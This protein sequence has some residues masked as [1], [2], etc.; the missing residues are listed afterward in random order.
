MEKRDLLAVV[1]AIGL[2]LIVALIIK[3]ALQGEGAAFFPGSGT[4][5]EFIPTPKA[6]PIAGPPT[7]E[8]TPTPLWDGT[9]RDV[10]FVNPATYHVEMAEPQP[11]AGI[12]AQ[13]PRDNLDLTTYATIDG[14]WSGTTEIITIPF[15]YWELYYTVTGMTDPG[16]VFPTINIQ[17]MDVSDPNRFVRIINPGVLDSRTWSENDPR[18][19]IEKFYEGERSYYFIITTRF[20][21]SYSMEIKVPTRYVS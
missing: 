12:P 7:P 10:S 17:V 6:T 4:E 15:P 11:T 3:P 18:P 2:V 21:E 16:Y 9:V 20:V 19:W 13:V 5:E 8:P 1:A 14:K